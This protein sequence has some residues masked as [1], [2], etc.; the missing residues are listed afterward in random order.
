L[1]DKIKFDAKRNIPTGGLAWASFIA[2]RLKK[3]L[4]YI[5]K[6][7]KGHGTQK[8]IEGKV[9]KNS[10]ILIVDDVATTGG[11]I[12]DGYEKLKDENYFVNYAFVI[13]DREEGAYNKLK[14]YGIELIS[15]FKLKDILNQIKEII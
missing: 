7:T 9:E 12:F 13:V 5:R 6:E 8:L 4:V 15:L 14:D 2:Y 3:P 10:E 11:N 1:I